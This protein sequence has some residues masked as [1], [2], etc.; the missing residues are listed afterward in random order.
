MMTV[1]L[2]PRSAYILVNLGAVFVLI[3]GAVLLLVGIGV[4]GI[5]CAILMF[6]F[7]IR[8]RED[9]TEH[10]RY[11]A[12]I[13]VISVL[14]WVG[15]LGGYLIGFLLGMIGGILAVTWVPSHVPNVAEARQYTGQGTQP[16]GRT[17]AFCSSPLPLGTRTCPVCGAEVQK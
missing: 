13:I 12:V 5:I 17:C 8:L 10:S 4:I 14:S 6:Y 9:P 7:A 1:E 2:Y 16:T 11:G 3:G 15:S